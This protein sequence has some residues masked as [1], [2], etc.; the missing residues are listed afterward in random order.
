MVAGCPFCQCHISDSVGVCGLWLIRM[1]PFNL[2][3]DPYGWFVR[4]HSTWWLIRVVH[5]YGWFVCAPSTWCLLSHRFPHVLHRFSTASPQRVPEGLFFRRRIPWRRLH[6]AVCRTL[7]EHRHIPGCRSDFYTLPRFASCPIMHC[8]VSA[9][10]ISRTTG[11]LKMEVLPVW[12]SH[13]LYASVNW[14]IARKWMYEQ[15]IE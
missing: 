14:D 6:A 15:V 11:D 7:H 3:V 12:V 5:P 1:C 2:V 8:I 9:Q 4:A 13:Y 10:F